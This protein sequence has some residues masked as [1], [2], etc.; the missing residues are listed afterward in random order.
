[1][2][3][4]MLGWDGFAGICLCRHNVSECILLLPVKPQSDVGCPV[5]EWDCTVCA[6]IHEK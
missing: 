3:E 4:G 1:M 2:F 5:C 6:T